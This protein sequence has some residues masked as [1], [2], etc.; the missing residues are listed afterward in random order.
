MSRS[1]DTTNSSWNFRFGRSSEKDGE[2]FHTPVSSHGTRQSREL[3]TSTSIH[4][5]HT[6]LKISPKDGS[7]QN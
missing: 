6:Q 7:K 3:K 2:R 1:A 5:C 4:C